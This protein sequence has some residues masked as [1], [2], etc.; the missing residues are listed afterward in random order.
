MRIAFHVPRARFLE[1]RP[2]GENHPSGD[3]V[4]IANLLDALRKRGHQVKIVSRLDMHDFWLGRLPARRLLAEAALVRG[5]MKRFSPDA[6]LVYHSR[7]NWPDLFGWWQRPK[8]YVILKGGAPGTKLL[9]ATMPRLW[10]ALYTFAYRRSLKRASAIEAYS[11]KDAQELRT[12]GVA[13]ERIHFLPR[14][15]KLWTLIPCREEA[16]R[17]LGLPQGNPIVLCVSRFTVRRSADDKRP[18]K[19]ESVLDLMRAF[20]ALPENALLMLVGDGPGRGQVEEEAARL[21]LVERV[22]LVGMVEHADVCWY[23]AACD[24]FAF[25]EKSETNSAFQASI[26][27]QG[28]GRPVVSM[29]NTRSQTMV[30]AGRTGLLAKDLAEFQAHL[31]VLAQDRGRCDEMG[32]AATKFVARSYTIDVWARQIE[33]LLLGRMDSSTAVAEHGHGYREHA[34]QC[35]PTLDAP[36]R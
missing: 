25:P 28:C 20:A 15:T 10:R 21:K 14:A 19:T 9:I 17:V 1:S 32:R 8:R 2:G 16:R 4:A 22:R 7:I 33:N 23:Y 13:E 30:D 36:G 27:A 31:L 34:A 3:G 5:E 6:W 24:F 35:P 26:E 18:G 29:L 12:Q 11:P